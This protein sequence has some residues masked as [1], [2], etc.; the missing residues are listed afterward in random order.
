MSK[1][2]SVALGFGLVFPAL[3]AAQTVQEQK[4]L[5]EWIDHPKFEVIASVAGGIP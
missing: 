2:K 4:P 5:A 1:G 3:A